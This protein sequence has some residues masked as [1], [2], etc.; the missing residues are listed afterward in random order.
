M[1]KMIISRD[2]YINDLKN[3]MHNGLIKV[4]T[5]VRRCGK[6]Y[7]LFNLFDQYLKKIGVSEQYIIKLALDDDLNEKFRDPSEFSTYIRSLI[8][9]S[10]KQYYLLFDEIQF[11]ISKEELAGKTDT[12]KIFSVLNGLLKLPNVDIYVTGSNSRFLSNDILTEFRGRGDEIHIYPFTFKEFLQGFEGDVYHAWATYLIYGGMPLLINMKTDNQKSNYLMNLFK[13][14]YIKD[15]INR[16]KIIKNQELE[17]LINILASS[18][19]S[20]NNPAKIQKSFK[21]MLHSNIS[22]NTII[23]FVDY[24]KEA[25]IISEVNRYDVKGRKY[26]GSP[27]KYY[28]EDIGL[29]NARLNFR[30]IEENHLMENII[31]NELKYRGYNVDVGIVEK[32]EIH[33]EKQQRVYYEIDFI[34]TQGSKKYYIQSALSMADLEKEKQEKQSLLNVVDSFKKIVVVKD[35]VQ[36]QHDENGITTINL[37]DFLLDPNSLDF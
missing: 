23:S 26:I 31:Y 36:V 21:S 9:D 13:E 1:D 25:F 30:Q 32:R 27:N 8:T 11:A 37:F 28:F 17:D 7:L 20:L 4:V 3:R 35:I 24:L 12:I 19:G 33:S 14:V 10:T 6:S 34:A 5:G 15:I 29:R 16:N 22:I 18:I 2:K